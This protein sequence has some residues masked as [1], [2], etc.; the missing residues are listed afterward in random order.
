MQEEFERNDQRK[1]E[2]KA[3]CA[4]AR[5]KEDRSEKSKKKDSVLCGWK[6]DSFLKDFDRFRR[7]VERSRYACKKC[8]RVAAEESWLCKPVRLV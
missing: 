4:K 1:C 7:I 5:S 6:K 3:T 8:G 2:D